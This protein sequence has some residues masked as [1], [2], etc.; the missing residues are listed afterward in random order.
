NRRPKYKVGGLV[1][2]LSDSMLALSLKPGLL[3]N[4]QEWAVDENNI[5][6]LRNGLPDTASLRLSSREQ[7]IALRTLPDTASRMPALRADIKNFQLATITGLLAADTM[8]ATGVLNAQ[9][10]ISNLDNAP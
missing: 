2:F 6:R 7:S 5:I 3:L 1:Q 4:K 9:A 8:L 10:R